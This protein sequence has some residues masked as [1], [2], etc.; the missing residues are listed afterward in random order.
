[1]NTKQ[2]ESIVK[3][4]KM[5]SV[6]DSRREPG[7]NSPAERE[8]LLQLNN[9]ISKVVT[10][11]Y[12]QRGMTQGDFADKIGYSRVSV[13][14]VFKNSDSTARMWKL[15][16]LVPA[17]EVLGVRVS[18][19]IAAA[20]AEAETPTPVTKPQIRRAVCITITTPTG[21]IG[22]MPEEYLASVKEN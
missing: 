14:L 6:S 15:Q 3:K 9:S 19:I 12:K 10:K 8:K 4:T 20:E 21:S 22:V 18:D 2:K 5:V 17:A 1:L 11:L 13:N 7:G 16:Y